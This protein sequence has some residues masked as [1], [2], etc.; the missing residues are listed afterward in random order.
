MFDRQHRVLLFM[1][2]I[3]RM[4]AR[5]I[6]WDRSG[7]AVS[8]NIDL[9]E[10]P[11]QLLN[12]ISRFA[13]MTPEQRGYDPT[14][15]FATKEQ[16]DR[17]RAYHSRDKN[18]DTTG[19]VKDI[20][21]NIR[22][23]P[24]YQVRCPV[25]DTPPIDADSSQ[26]PPSRQF[27]IGKYLS[28][29]HSLTGRAT[30]GYIA[31]DIE[32][33]RLVFLKDY[34]RPDADGVHP[35]LDVYARLKQNNVRFVATA[36]GGGDVG[37]SRAQ[38]TGTQELIP[39][40]K[41]PKARIHYRVL[42]EQVGQPLEKYYNSYF[43]LAFVAHALIGMGYFDS[44]PTCFVLVD[45]AS[46]RS[47]RSLGESADFTPRRECQ[48]YSHSCQFTGRQVDWVPQRLGHVQI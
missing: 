33:E 34:W 39:E 5:L 22:L 4:R 44:L 20:L 12:F 41:R 16:L 13:T 11:G 9:K 21:D 3:T 30:R 47:S 35:E 46:C 26:P 36:I 28:A 43:M 32:K 48:Q 24:I 25:I 38:L 6:C 40:P 17:L 27:L 18:E 8:E 10:N 31:F 14:A 23:Y 29:S 42:L 1:I 19:F 45:S 2:Y 37:G 7:A 15:D